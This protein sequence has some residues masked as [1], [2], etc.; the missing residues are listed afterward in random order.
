MRCLFYEIF[1]VPRPLI[2]VSFYTRH[3]PHWH[4]PDAEF[5]VTWRLHGSLP[6][7]SREAEPSQPAGAAFVAQDRELDRAASGP[8]A[9]ERTSGR[10]CERNPA[11]RNVALGIL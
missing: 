9:E 11:R 1:S 10:V 8:M 3:L 5:F 6:K 4:P 7:A 2:G